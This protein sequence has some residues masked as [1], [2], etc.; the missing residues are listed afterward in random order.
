[1][2]EIDKPK[3]EEPL[4][5]WKVALCAFGAICSL[6]VFLIG[7]DLM[8]SS[9]KVLGGRGASSMFEAVDNPLAGLMTGI[10]ATVLVQSSSTST[11]IVV[12]LVGE[13]GLTVKNGIPIIM[14]A[15]IGTSVTNTIVSMGSVGD[16]IML[17]RAFAGATVHDMF[18]MLTVL[19]LLP[20]EALIGAIQGEGGILYW[21]TKGIAEAL[22]EGSEGDPLF[23]S[24]I[25]IITG[26]IADGILKADKYVIYALTLDEPKTFSTVP[27]NFKN[28]T[29]SGRRMSASNET[30][31]ESP[32]RSLLNRRSD[33][34]LAEDCSKYTCLSSTLDKQFKKI[35]ES[36]Y[37]KLH[38]CSAYLQTTQCSTSQKVC[39]LDG[40]AFY[41]KKVKDGRLIKGGFVKGAGDG[42]GG[43]IGLILSLILLTLGLIGL[44]KSLQM[45]FMGSAKKI[46]VYATKLNGYIAILIGI[47]IT[48]I[49]QSSSVTTSALTPLCGVG[50]L[51]LDKMLPLT[52]GANIGTTCTAFIASMVTFKVDAV[53]IALCHLFFNIV[54]ILIWYP[55][56]P[57]R[58]IPLTAAKKLGLYAAFFRL[59]PLI[60]ILVMF[61]LA[62]GIFLA[63]SA[64]IDANAAAGII[65]L[66]F[67]LAC[68]GA[69]LFLWNIGYPKGNALCYKVLSEKDREDGKRELE[70]ADSKLYC[71]TMGLDKDA[72]ED[73][74]V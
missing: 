41:D 2:A 44:S 33:R 48:I 6:Y 61:V 8:G 43:I 28:G 68:L 39:Y 24:P 54:G 49:V 73:Q 60:Y 70:E 13:G 10:L 64:I 69:F 23:E 65:V 19:V 18:N 38:K 16:K 42:G 40:Q 50:V 11:S 66:L 29:C 55:I 22:L 46:I 74:Q 36:S 20:L 35:S 62:P 45:I 57:M 53:Q 59:V 31:D 72:G 34:R 51:P 7:L 47:V 9:F 3:I 32:T 37:K 15:N 52:L 58:Q 1:M 12:A 71:Q 17:E 26:P 27:A 67:A 5:C 21:I 30:F 63:I 25:S 14:G 4:P 56:P